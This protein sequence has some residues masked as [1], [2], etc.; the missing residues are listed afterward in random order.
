MSTTLTQEQKARIYCV[1]YGHARYYTQFFGYVYCG[2]CGDQIGDTLG[3]VFHPPE[4]CLFLS[5]KDAATHDYNCA[6]C[7]ALKKTLSPLDKK[8][9][10]RLIRM[11]KRGKQP[12]GDRSDVLRGLVIPEVE[13]IAN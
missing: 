2:R 9:L 6:S 13:A 3:G 4:P 7:R 11:V 5:G 8:I 1:K 12:T 10:A